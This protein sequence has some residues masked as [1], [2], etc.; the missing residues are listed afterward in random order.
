MLGDLPVRLTGS[1][2][3]YEIPGYSRYAIAFDGRVL[4]KQTKEFLTGSVN[5]DGYVNYRLTGDDSVVFTWG[6]HRLLGYVFLHPGV[7]ISNLVINHKNGIKGD[8]RLENLE[9]VTYQENTEHAGLFG[10]TEKCLPISVRD[11]DTGAVVEF[12]SIIE[13]ARSLGMT[14]DAISYRVKN[15]DRRIFP[16]RKQ[17]RLSRI[18]TPWYIP[19]DIDCELKRNGKAKGVL[20]R[21]VLTGEVKEFDKLTDLSEAFNIPLPTLTLWLSAKNQP[22][23]P[24]F[25]QLKWC[26]D[27]TPWRCVQDPILELGQYTG[28]KPVKVMNEKT[29]E[30]KVYISASE[31]AKDKQLSPTALNYRLKS[32]GQTVFSDNCRYGYYPFN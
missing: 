11:I 4:N 15:G 21:R 17:Y 20:V 28:T 29:G 30:E 2:S 3:F 23:L 32:K 1:Y 7:D 16:E 24:G 6:R 13:C 25:I 9:L 19:S 18:K 14:K 10:L 31:C 5:P 22:V 12:A 27:K 8:D 26:F